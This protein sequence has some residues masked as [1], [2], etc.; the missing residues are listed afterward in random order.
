MSSS[1]IVLVV[2]LVVVLEMPVLAGKS[3]RTRTSTRTRPEPYREQILDTGTLG[4]QGE[5]GERRTSNIQRSTLN[6]RKEGR[7]DS[8]MDGMKGGEVSGVREETAEDGL[9]RFGRAQRRQGCQGRRAEETALRFAACLTTKLD[10]SRPSALR[11]RLEESAGTTADRK[12]PIAARL[13]LPRL[14]Q[15]RT[16]LSRVAGGFNPRTMAGGVLNRPEGAGQSCQ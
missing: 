6:G 1:A 11:L 9:R 3:S 12:E 7:R 14:W 5:Q 10:P 13:S 4:R 8:G 15:P 2:E 16:G